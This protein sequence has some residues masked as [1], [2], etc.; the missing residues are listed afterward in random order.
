[1]AVLVG[2]GERFELDVTVAAIDNNNVQYE[3]TKTF[4]FNPGVT[5]Y[6]DALIA[7]AALL[8]AL[9]AINEADIIKYTLRTVYDESTGPVTAVGNVRKEA[10]LS[11]RI[12]GSSKK[13]NHKIF[14]PYDAMISG[15]AVV[16]TAALQTYLD[17]FETGGD[18]V[19]SDGESI[20]TDEATRIA[21]SG[22]THVAGPKS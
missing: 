22:I 13:E 15:K 6:A 14:S 8:A 16:S 4:E 5:V 20:S 17:L 19:I 11:L 12:A 21:A 7:T 10:S 18:F 2:V 1:M 9:D 3:R